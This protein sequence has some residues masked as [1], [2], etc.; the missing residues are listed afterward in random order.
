MYKIIG[1]MDDISK[2]KTVN[3]VMDIVEIIRS[4][5][6]IND[7]NDIMFLYLKCFNM[8]NKVM[9]DQGNVYLNDVREMMTG[10]HVDKFL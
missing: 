6:T 8:I 10:K 1:Y 4:D 7:T 2:C 9:N 3:H 5:D